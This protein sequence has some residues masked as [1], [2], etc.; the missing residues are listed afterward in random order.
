MRTLLVLAIT[1]GATHASAHVAPSVDDNNRYLKLTPAADRVRLAYTVFY[2]EVPGAQLRRTL[3]ADHDGRIDDAEANA[4]GERV[5]G[6]VADALELAID[7]RNYRVSWT[8]VS[9]GLGTPVTAGG[10]FSVDLIAWACLPSVRGTH[11]VTLRDRF[12]L[13]RPGET[14]VK[15]DDGLGITIH[16]ARIGRIEDPARDYRFVGP[17]GPLADEGLDV[18]FTASERAP[19]T[20]DATCAPAAASRRAPAPLVI[21]AMLALASALVWLSL[22]H[23]KR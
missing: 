20:D 11:A 18:S 6:E 10:A 23:N 12:R 3:D 7:G 8:T 21:A 2:G 13:P 16:R 19:L 9:V 22:P 15:I 1:L 14:E 4:F 5:A 17:G